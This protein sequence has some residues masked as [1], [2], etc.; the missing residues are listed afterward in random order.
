M[1]ENTEKYFLYIFKCFYQGQECEPPKYHIDFNYLYKLSR[2]HDT[3]GI[4]FYKI[5]NLEVFKSSD[6]Y[7][8]FRMD[9]FSLARQS[10]FTDKNL[11]YLTNVLTE[12]K[13][14][15]TLFKGSVLR[16]FYPDKVLR[17]MG[18]IDV[19]VEEEYTQKMILSLKKA[20]FNFETEHFHGNANVFNYNGTEFEVHSIVASRN[21][22]IHSGNFVEFFRK[23]QSHIIKKGEYTYIFEPEY[24]IVF[25]MYHLL[26][27]FERNGCGIRMFLDFPF[28]MDGNSDCIDLEKVKVLLEE[29]D[30]VDF[31]K[32]VLHFCEYAFGYKVPEILKS[33]IDEDVFSLFKNK[34]INAGT[35]GFSTEETISAKIQRGKINTGS[36]S[37][38]MG[39]LKMI[40]PSRE[41]MHD[42]GVWNKSIPKI[43]LPVGYVKRIFIQIFK[44]KKGLEFIKSYSSYTEDELNYRMLKE[45]GIS[46]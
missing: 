31:A 14:P 4:I 39:A 33:N 36:S 2:M 46:R 19:L 8:R 17:T 12:N 40:F 23:A 27:H 28:F 42:S 15:H 32:A 7:E 38:L 30:L 10:I 44:K 26:K 6:C 25:L 9:F 5:Q 21:C 24:H 13:I 22:T 3:Q 20:G 41:Y 16:D 45:I 34:I 35:F 11:L 43:F 1:K 18:D 37:K 29:L